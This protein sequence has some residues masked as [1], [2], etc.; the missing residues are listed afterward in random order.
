MVI[1]WKCMLLEWNAML[2]LDQW[3]FSFCHISMFFKK[4]ILYI[5]HYIDIEQYICTGINNLQVLPN[6]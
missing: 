3:W 5:K 4:H 6:K 1:P 2:I